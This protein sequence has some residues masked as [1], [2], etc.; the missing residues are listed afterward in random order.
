[1][2]KRSLQ[3]KP[4]PSGWRVRQRGKKAKFIITFRAPPALR[5]LWDDKS[6]P[7]LGEGKTL[8]EAENQ[9][10]ETWKNRIY[11]FT[12]PMTMGDLFNRYQTE[13]IP[14][15]AEQTQAYNLKSMKRV[16]KIIDAKMPIMAFNT[17]MVFAYRDNVAKKV[18]AKSANS[19][20]ELLSHMFTK[21]FEWGV[22]IQEHPIKQKVQKEKINTR[23]YRKNM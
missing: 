17:H 8:A 13:V 1:M 3:N 12:T 2:K 20:L 15:K 23:T 21:C 22:P 11:Q 19:D 10:Y 4:Y 6:E 7:K 14:E 9:A 18:G 16:R 5:K